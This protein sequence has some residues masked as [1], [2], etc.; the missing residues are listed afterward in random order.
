MI[1]YQNILP[2]LIK[3]GPLTIRWYGLFFAIGLLLAYLFLWHIF[4]SE[5]L[6]LNH[7]DTVVLYLFVGMFIGARLGHVF[8][9][10]PGYYLSN[11]IEILK[12]W[13][14]GLASHGAAIGVLFAYLIWLKVYKIKFSQYIDYLI[15]GFPIVSTFVRLANFFNS[16]IIGQPTNGQWGV[17]FQQ[18]G[19]DFPRHPTQ[20][21]ESG[22]SLIIFIILFII[23]K[24]YSKKLPTYFNLFLYIFLYFITRFIV[25]FWKERHII[26]DSFPLSMGQILSILPILIATGYFVYLIFN[27]KDEKN[28]LQ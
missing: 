10:E 13:K 8:F 11:P 6:N 2:I 1:F 5:K 19:E 15:L 21:Y 20:L 7:L 26:P 27:K 14:G 25:E 3:L 12:V 23:Y 24:K 18:L 22:L 4:K 28:I 9:Y 16:E 17:V